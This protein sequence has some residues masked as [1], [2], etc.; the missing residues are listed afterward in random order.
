MATYP[1]IDGEAA[2][3][4]EKLMT[5]MLR[6]EMGFDGIVL[7]EGD[8]LSTIITEGHTATQKETGVLALKA[9]VDVG[10]SIEDAYMGDLI[11]NVNEGTIPMSQVIRQWKESYVL[12]FRWVFSKTPFVDVEHAVKIVNSEE[13]KQLALQTSRESIVLLKNEKNTLP[14]KKGIKSI[15]VIG[16]NAV[17]P[18]DQLGDYIPQTVPQHVFTILEGIQE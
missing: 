18:V 11:E 16:P 8:G 3:S 5:K 7:G 15:A 17:A 14:L 6:E 4:S 9:G 13:H 10:I 1:A 2:H 12:N